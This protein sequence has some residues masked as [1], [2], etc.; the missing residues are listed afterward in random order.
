MEHI[1]KI[2]NDDNYFRKL[3]SLYQLFRF[4]TLLNKYDEL[5]YRAG[6]IFAPEVFVLYKKVWRP[7]G[8][9]LSNFDIIVL[10]INKTSFKLFVIQ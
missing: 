10:G 5:Y 2:V 8:L 4:Y 7:R 3:F 9:G 1:A 6:L